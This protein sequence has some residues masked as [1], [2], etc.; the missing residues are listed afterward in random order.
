MKYL[1]VF[2]DTNNRG[3]QRKSPAKAKAKKLKIKVT[4]PVNIRSS[5]ANF[6]SP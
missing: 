3:K 6:I 2:H 1:G 4:I 5:G